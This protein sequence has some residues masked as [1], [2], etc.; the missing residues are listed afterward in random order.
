MFYTRKLQSVG[1]KDTALVGGK[2]ASLG[3]MITDLSK[4]GVRVPGGFAVTTQGYWLHLSENNL[5]QKFKALFKGITVNTPLETIQK[6]GKKARD[7]I[8]SAPL[9]TSLS[10]E[11]TQAYQE[12]CIEVG[13][14]CSVAVRSS[15]TAEDLPDASFAGQQESYL[16]VCG[17]Q[18]VLAACRESM[19]SL[20]TDRAIV[21]RM[22]KKFD[23]FSVAL[24]V[25]VQQ[26][27]RSDLA[28][29]GVIFTVDTET[30]FENV[31]V[32]TSSYGLGESVVKG[33]VIPDEFHVFKP[34]FSAGYKPLI[35]KQCGTKL[36]ERVYGTQKNP[37]KIKRVAAKRAQRLSL[38]DEEV[39]ELTG[40]ALTI[41]KHYSQLK[42]GWCPMDIEWA[43]DGITGQLYIVQARPETIHSLKKESAHVLRTY[44]LSGTKTATIL[45][46]G[47]SIGQQATSG[48]ACVISSAKE[49]KK[50]K[51]GDIVVTKMTDPDWVPIMKR[52]AGIITES[53]GRTCH[54][55]I[56]S[57]ELGIPAI[58]GAQ[59]ALKKIKHGQMVTMDCSS[60]SQGIIYAG[61]LP[62]EIKEIELKNFKSPV[63]L[64]VN[65]A[66]PDRAY[67]TAQLPVEG[68][69]LAR[70][71]FIISNEIQVHPMAFVSSKKKLD[72]K[73]QAHIK[74]ITVDYAT[75]E[76]FFIETLA[77]GVGTIA[78]AFFPRSVLVRFSDFKSNE[79][80]NLVGG[81]LFEPIEENPMMGLRGASRYNS[82]LYA[83]AFELECRALRYVRETMGLTNVNVMIP[84]VRTV[85]E[86]QLVIELLKKNGL[87]SGN[88]GLKIFMMCEIPSNVILIE[89]FAKLFDG[90]SIGSND[91]TQTTLS[92][93]RDSGLLAALFD[94]RDPAVL[95]ML[96][97]AIAGAHRAQRPIGIC[98][99]AP[100]DYPEIAQFLIEKKI[101]SMSLNADSVI[102]FLIS[103]SS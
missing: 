88:N 12:L 4:Q 20:F 33:E 48:K 34:T 24:S 54:A 19:A 85:P 41:E 38:T 26:M 49:I 39:F 21:Y 42:G 53:G 90:F 56:V 55:A 63:S 87:V 92:I 60:G 57:R 46:L 15:A 59:G 72:A 93:D 9:P 18:A 71:E 11:I 10:Q 73:V 13:H 8:L 47:Q 65:I 43:K 69:G 7:L 1:L 29:A 16:N 31:V 27:V 103:C 52:A 76:D 99:Q 45:A 84:F 68:V 44:S 5:T 37:I 101:D 80:R 32:I 102:P 86:A 62:L 83:P 97:E 70:V 50:V 78:A 95:Y 3:Q 58:V 22:E 67:Q 81:S 17:A 64:L 28:S 30:G 14:D 61:K 36:I 66:A 75:P 40:H 79:Y 51:K 89:Q 100:S 94:E 25:G 23:H 91:L 82:P 74:K 2:N 6:V 77:Q 96:Q 35:K 98:G